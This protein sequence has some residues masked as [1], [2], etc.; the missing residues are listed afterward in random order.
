MSFLHSIGIGDIVIVKLHLSILMPILKG[1]SSW[2]RVKMPY[3]LNFQNYVTQN[4]KH[5]F[6]QMFK[7]EIVQFKFT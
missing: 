2:F 6:L 4:P 5:V 7:Q 1:L 3:L